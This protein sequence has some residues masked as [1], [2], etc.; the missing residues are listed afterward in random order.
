MISGCEA[1]AAA[2]APPAS[3]ASRTTMR[4]AASAARPASRRARRCLRRPGFSSPRSPCGEAS[5]PPAGLTQDGD[6]SSSGTPYPAFSIRLLAAA[7]ASRVISAP[8]SMRA[9]SSR[10]SAGPSVTTRVATPA[11]A[12]SLTILKWRS[13]ARRHLRRVGHRQ[14]LRARRQPRQPLTDRVG[15]RAADARVDLVEHQRRRGLAL[16]QRHFEREQKARQLAARGH[17]HQRTRARAG[18]GLNDELDA[19]VAVGGDELFIADDFGRKARAREL[20]RR[21]A[22]H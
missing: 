8:A 15:D 9:I 10:R 20:Q 1:L 17:L 14:H 16:G 19:V 11:P 12:S 21:R 4:R 5:G 22:P 6:V 3:T 2:I 13:R 7:R 18:I